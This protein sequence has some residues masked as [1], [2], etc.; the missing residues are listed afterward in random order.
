[1]RN[2]VKREDMKM[3]H[4]DRQQKIF[5]A[6]FFVTI[7]LFFAFFLYMG[8]SEQVSVYRSEETRGYRVIT[9]P[10]TELVPDDTAPIG[11]RKV[12]R[13]VLEPE[14]VKGS[15]LLF[16]ISHHEI[17]VFFD[18]ELVYRLTGAEGN[19]IGSN[20]SNNWC[21]V[22]AGPE[23]TGQTVTVIL[24]PLLEA[25]MEKQPEFLFGSH[26][27]VMQSVVRGELPVLI[28]S[29][30]C[31]LLG[32]LVFWAFLYFRMVK[33][34]Q[35]EHLYYL[36]LFSL[37]MGL[38]KL[39]DL[40]CITLLYPQHAMAAGYISVGALFLTG[41]CLMNY[42]RTLFPP[43]RQRAMHLLSFCGSLAC[44][45]VLGLQVLGVVEIRQNLL[46]SHM[47]LI[48]AILSL[49]V[50]AVFNRVLYRD[51]GL[52]RS[53]K[54]LLLLPAGITLDLLLYYR[55]NGNGT[56]SFS[57]MSFILYTLLI[58]LGSVQDATQ[59]AY[60]DSRTGLVNRT[61]WNEL[62]NAP[63]SAS[64]AYAI[65]VVD[66]NGLKRVNDTL[67]H[68][69]GDQMI[70]ALSQ[71]LRNSLPRSSVICRWGGDEFTALLTG[72]NRERLAQHLQMLFAE[73]EQYNLDHPEL[74]VHFAVGAALS[75]EHPGLSQTQLFQLADEDMYRS[76]QQWYAGRQAESGRMP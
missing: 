16:N 54:L 28:L 50:V 61:R 21:F 23:R 44:L 8:T 36:G 19:R 51:W 64:E 2:L 39:M 13:W 17:S 69:A 57:I 3:N 74:P 67:G 47:L 15:S 27:S 7:L 62:M 41:L 12:Y 37:S 6:L 9:D 66:L 30:L 42:F 29:A 33:H 55:N 4:S 22:Y 68:E 45:A 14:Q 24:T 10:Q 20:V 76:K 58:F 25:A 49:P 38:W 70:L 56:I 53:W 34:Q 18:D 52:N 75:I 65:L 43:E 63:V 59:K 46:I 26:W 48:A 72:V 73:G 5:S 35:T 1:M 40:R 32:L 31:I 71:I 60:I 11:V